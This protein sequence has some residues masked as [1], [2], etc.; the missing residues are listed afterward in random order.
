MAEEKFDED[1]PVDKLVDGLAAAD[2]VLQDALKAYSARNK[3]FPK[4]GP[5]MEMASGF[6]AVCFCREAVAYATF[7]VS[8]LWGRCQHYHNEKG[9]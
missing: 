3:D 9:E 8:T 6:D 5:A 2:K 4:W 1:N 7:A